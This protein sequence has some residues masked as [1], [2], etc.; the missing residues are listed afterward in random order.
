[1]TTA[2]PASIT[3]KKPGT[4]KG[5][6]RAVEA[7]RKGGIVVSQERGADYFRT[8]GAKGGQTTAEKYGREF[9]AQIGRKGGNALKE[10]RGI[11]FFTTIGR[12][13]AQSKAK[14]NAK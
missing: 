8:I 14:N 6:P 12:K 13:G 2:L 3:R 10:E 1:M 11:E 7:G 5:D 4:K 9:F